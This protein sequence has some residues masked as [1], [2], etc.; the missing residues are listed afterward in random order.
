MTLEWTYSGADTSIWTVSYEDEA[1]K[2]QS[3]TAENMPHAGETCSF[4]VQGLEAGRTY[5]FSVSCVGMASPSVVV[6]AVPDGAI[7]GFDAT[8]SGQSITLQWT[9]E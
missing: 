1:G 4:T 6:A 9:W 5:T 2:A 7:S 3:V 8:A